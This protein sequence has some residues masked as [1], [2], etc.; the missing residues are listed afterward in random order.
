M[1]KETAS[2]SEALISIYEHTGRHITNDWYLR[3]H[4]CQKL[5]SW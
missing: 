2:T 1:N 3:Q 5:S 4:V